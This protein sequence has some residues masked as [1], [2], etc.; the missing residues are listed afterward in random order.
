MG[1]HA[2]P[3]GLA[4]FVGAGLGFFPA[5]A[6]AAAAPAFAAFVGAGPGLFPAF[7]AAAAAPVFAAFVGA[8]PGL[9]PAFAAAA[10]APAFAAAVAAAFG[11][12][13]HS[14]QPLHRSA[15]AHLTDQA[16]CFS[17]WQM[18][19]QVPAEGLAAFEASLA[20]LDLAASFACTDGTPPRMSLTPIGSSTVA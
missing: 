9:F 7:A 2:P 20:P 18:G 14:S 6:A 5:F 16:L 17:A 15:Q 11:G 3:E 8:G 13:V 1:R 19:R 4:A 12:P 10:A